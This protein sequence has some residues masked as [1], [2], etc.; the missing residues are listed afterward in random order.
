MALSCQKHLFSLD[1]GVHYLN[2]AAYSPALT[3][4]VDRGLEGLRLKA[5]TP[6]L[7]TPR[8]HFDTAGRV[9]QLFSDLVNAADADRI[10][11]IPAVSYGMAVV[12]QNLHRLPGIAAKNRIVLIGEEFP[13][14]VYAFERA[15][16][17][18]GLTAHTV[19]KPA[20]YEN[21]GAAWNE[22]LL[23]AITPETALVVASAVHWIYGVLFDLEAIGR[24]CREVGALL[25][26]DATQS[27]GAMPFDVQAVRPDALICAA[28]KWLL[29]PYGSGAAYFGP[30]FDEGVP[31]EESWMNRAESDQFARLTR[32]ERAYR[33]KA[34]RYN[35]GEF[36]QFD[37]LPMLEVS[38]RQLIT[39]G[40]ASIQ[41]YCR[42]LCETAVPEWQALGCRL[43]EP[44]Q[45]AAHLFGLSLPEHADTQKFIGLLAERKVFVSL[46]GG[47]VRVSPNVYN[48]TADVEAF[49]DALSEIINLG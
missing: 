5:E 3:A 23:E 14:N 20:T 2:G 4:A 32:Y 12:A 27:V 18:L 47:A 8:H 44:S 13:N 35:A 26:V 39:W 45:R 33:P 1:P 37:H 36:S 38:L 42:Q 11:L 29:G 48:D 34:Q 15:G 21:R 40:A 49:T 30:F 28:Y 19:E 7:I 41:T 24:R 25:V 16:A 10:A 6:F 9:R 43:D 31:V 17:V 22:R 46:R